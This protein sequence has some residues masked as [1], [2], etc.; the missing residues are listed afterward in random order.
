MNTLN[1]LNTLALL[2]KVNSMNNSGT[3][4]KK[5]AYNSNQSDKS[6]EMLKKVLVK[7]DLIANKL[8][9][10]FGAKESEIKSDE[11]IKEYTEILINIYD[12][13]YDILR[14]LKNEDGNNT[15]AISALSNIKAKLENEM[16]KVSIAIDEP[17]GKPFNP[18]FHKAVKVVQRKDE[19]SNVIT[20]VIK[21][22]IYINDKLF[23]EAEVVV[24]ANN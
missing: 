21:P 19:D 6:Y 23:R 1:T 9:S 18:R 10:F 2:E 16:K 12:K 13:V 5:D 8:D 15:M 17:F 3:D 20:D 14:T 22:G 4:S 24:S 7:T 11:D